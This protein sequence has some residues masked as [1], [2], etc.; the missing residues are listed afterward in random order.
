MKRL[1]L[2]RLRLHRQLRF[3]AETEPE[4]A[5]SESDLI[6]TLLASLEKDPPSGPA[7]QIELLEAQCRDLN[8]LV[9]EHLETD[10]DELGR[11]IR[12]LQLESQIEKFFNPE[13]R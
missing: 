5:V 13:S 4:K 3:L 11:E 1:R 9:L 12:A 2:L 10:Q 8:D 7:D 6:G